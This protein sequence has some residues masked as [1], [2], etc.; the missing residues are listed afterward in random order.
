MSE[1]HEQHV[2]NFLDPPSWQRNTYEP[3]FS[4]VRHN[5]NSIQ[6]TLRRPDLLLS[7]TIILFSM[8]HSVRS[9]EQADAA[10][11]TTIQPTYEV[12]SAVIIGRRSNCY[13]EAILSIKFQSICNC[14]FGTFLRNKQLLHCWAFPRRKFVGA[15]T[16]Q[17]YTNCERV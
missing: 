12:F 11:I 2:F 8:V 15:M 17:K 9:E 1:I 16:K 4:F 6:T 5:N 7:G 14:I 13:S 10:A 3:K